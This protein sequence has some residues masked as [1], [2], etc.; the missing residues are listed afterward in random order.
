MGSY[1]NI[2]KNKRKKDKNNKLEKI[3]EIE[4]NKI[5]EEITE[6]ILKKSFILMLSIPTMVLHDKYAYLTRKVDEKG[7]NRIERFVDLCLDNYEMIMS[8]NVS[9]EE[10]IKI[11]KEESGIDLYEIS[12]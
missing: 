6:E 10:L 3:N 5:K 4:L 2:K 12:K 11:L 8:N 7:R 9:I 1:Y